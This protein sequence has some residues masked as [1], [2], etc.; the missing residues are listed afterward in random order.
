MRAAFAL[1]LAHGTLPWQPA[2]D[3]GWIPRQP[4]EAVARGEAAAIPVV[5]G[6]NR[7]EWKLFTLLDARTRRLDAHGL[8]RRL[9]RLVPGHDEEGVAFAERAL[10]VYRRARAGR[11]ADAPPAL[12]EA[13]QTDRIF[14]YPAVRLAEL[15]AR[16]EPRTYA[17]LFDWTPRL[18]RQRVGACH[19]LEIPFVFG[20]LQHPL[21]RVLLGRAGGAAELSRAL[22]DAWVAFARHGEPKAPAL[23]AWEPYDARRRATMVL[24]RHSGVVRAPLDEER[25]FWDAHL[26]R[27]VA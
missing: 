18:A 24:G 26:A 13:I 12:W 4:L 7:D 22:R 27:P 15:Q 14:R 3:E 5:V 10:E 19:G 17:Y 9:A 20:T 23:D 6:T 21:F 8:R 11:E 2:V 1:G 25:R 16:H